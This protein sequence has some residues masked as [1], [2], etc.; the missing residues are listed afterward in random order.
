[1]QLRLSRE[2]QKSKQTS[3]F[4]AETLVA[5]VKIYKFNG[6]MFIV[7]FAFC[8]A[9]IFFRFNVSVNS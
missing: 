6:Q 7:Y 3:T 9:I 4:M 2:S 5:N 8:L 1:M